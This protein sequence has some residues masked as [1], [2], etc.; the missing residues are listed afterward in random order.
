VKRLGDGMMAI[1]EEP[2]EALAALVEAR[3]RLAGVS[4]P[5]YQPQM[6]AGIHLGRPRKIGGDYVG[7]DVNVAARVADGAGPDE[8]LA[9]DR[10]TAAL[11]AGKLELRKKRFFRAKGVPSD[12]T[13]YSVEAKR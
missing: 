5:G 2:D 10:A 6:R 1:F 9:S 7:V 11:E 3:E 8:I 12:I 13:V 4:A